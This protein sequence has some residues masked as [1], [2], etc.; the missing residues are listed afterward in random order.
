MRTDGWD[1]WVLSPEFLEEPPPEALDIDALNYMGA[2]GWELITTDNI[3][4][5]NPNDRGYYRI[6]LLY[7]FKRELKPTDL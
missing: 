1:Q 7:F 3:R 5:V 6:R 2:H 4:D